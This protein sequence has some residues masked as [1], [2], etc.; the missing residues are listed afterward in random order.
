M[1]YR[2]DSTLLS[3][4]WPRERTSTDLRDFTE[5]KRARNMRLQNVVKNQLLALSEPPDEFTSLDGQLVEIGKSSKDSIL[6]LANYDGGWGQVKLVV[7]EYRACDNAI[8]IAPNGIFEES[9]A[10]IRNWLGYS[11]APLTWMR[12]TWSQISPILDLHTPMFGIL[13]DTSM[14]WTKVAR[15][16]SIS[17]HK[18]GICS[19]L[20]TSSLFMIALM[21]PV[22]SLCM[23]CSAHGNGVG[24]K[25]S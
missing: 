4:F 11:A 8:K 12:K 10:P 25:A 3:L 13:W 9:M 23:L 15:P 5:S 24:R 16:F 17:F 1:S 18:W 22:S 20:Q 6:E 21:I 19:P 2:G 14:T 7:V